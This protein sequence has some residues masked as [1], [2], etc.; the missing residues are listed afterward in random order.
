[1]GCD[2]RHVEEETLVEAYLMAWNALVESR[3]AFMER[4][5]EQILC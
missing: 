4:W 1:M 5:K 3:E 2:N